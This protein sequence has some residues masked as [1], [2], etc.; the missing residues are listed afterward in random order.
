MEEFVT[1]YINID[2]SNETTASNFNYEPRMNSLKIHLNT[3]NTSYDTINNQFLS[4]KKHKKEN[5]YKIYF[6]IFYKKEL[7]NSYATLIA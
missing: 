7:N 1:K 4:S 5:P 3:Q 6:P 2:R